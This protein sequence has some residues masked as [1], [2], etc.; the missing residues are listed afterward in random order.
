MFMMTANIMTINCFLITLLVYGMQRFVMSNAAFTEVFVMM[1]SVNSAA[2]TMQATHAR[3]APC[4]SPA[5]TFVKMCWKTSTLVPDSTV[6]PVNQAYCS[7][8]RM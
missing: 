3:T 4:S 7:S 6:H 5:L 2:L 8:L 1:E